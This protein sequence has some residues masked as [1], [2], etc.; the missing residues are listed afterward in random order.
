MTE[1]IIPEGFRN[2]PGRPD[3]AISAKGEVFNRRTNQIMVSEDSSGL[4]EGRET[5]PG[6]VRTFSID[7]KF[8]VSVVFP[9]N[10]GLF[11]HASSTE[12]VGA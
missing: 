7:T 11:S 8:V 6:H 5:S 10:V 1:S 12:T 2:I 4:I 9:E 3:Y